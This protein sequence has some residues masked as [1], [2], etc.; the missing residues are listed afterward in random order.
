MEKTIKILIIGMIL[1]FLGADCY[2]T[3]ETE[4]TA[5]NE[6]AE[7]QNQNTT[8]TN[9]TKPQV[10]EKP[11]ET[12]KNETMYVQERCNIR[13]SYSVESDRVGGLGVGTE[14][15]VIA[16]YSNGW[17]KIRY[18][19]GE[20]YI[21]AGILRSTKPVIP[22]PEPVP[23]PEIPQE[24]PVSE[25]SQNQAPEEPVAANIEDNDLVK[26]IGILPEVGKNIADYLYMTAILL[27]LVAVMGINLS[28]RK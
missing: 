21:K 25:E 16:E 12:K 24:Q 22:E 13:S 17:Y 11:T 3:A 1:I 2:A 10:P 28:K 27:A 15:T 23:E 9:E 18:D 7:P 20:A 26:E 19:G 6:V 4:N 14:V 8:L 5:K